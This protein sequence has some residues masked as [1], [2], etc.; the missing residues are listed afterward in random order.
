MPYDPTIFNINPYYDDY[1]PQKGFLRVLF[2]PGYALQ[3]R[4]A[5]QI[6]SILQNQLSSVADHLF[7]DGARI[8]GGAISIR[9]AD[10]LMIK[11]TGTP[12]APNVLQG[13]TDF[14]FLVG[15]YVSVGSGSASTLAKVVHYIEPDPETDN[16][17][18]LILDFLSGT[19]FAG[20]TTVKWAS[21][22]D[23]LPPE[24]ALTSIVRTETLQVETKSWASGRCKLV[25]VDDGIFY[26][27][28]FFVYSQQ[29]NFSPYR[30]ITLSTPDTT[31]PSGKVRDLGFGNFALLNKK[32][33]FSV[34]RDNVTDQEDTTLRDPAIGSYNYNA[35]GAD[36]YK[37]VLSMD[38]LDGDDEVPDFVEL[39]KYEDG[40]VI[41][42]VERVAYGE[43]EKALAIR[44]YDESGSYTVSLNEVQIREG[45]GNTMSVQIGPGKSYVLGH[46]LENNNTVF[47]DL[48]KARDVEYKAS[49]GNTYQFSVSLYTGVS[50]G[51]SNSFGETFGRYF[52]RICGGQ[53]QITAYGSTGAIVNRSSVHGMIPY[54]QNN[55]SGGVGK[56]GNHY[57]MYFNGISGGPGL[58]GYIY[59]SGIT[60]GYISGTAAGSNFAV[61]RGALDSQTL[62]YPLKP[63]NAVDNITSFRTRFKVASGQDNTTNSYVNISTSPSGITTY[64]KVY[65]S[66]LYDISTAGDN[67][68]NFP[69]YTNVTGSGNSN[70]FKHLAFVWAGSGNSAGLAFVPNG[71]NA[72]LNTG[73]DENGSYLEFAMPANLY[74][75]GFTASTA[76]IRAVVPIEY[77]PNIPTD[78]SAP[79]DFRYKVL[80]GTTFTI[81]SSVGN[82]DT[83]INLSTAYG[84]QRKSFPLGHS[85]IHSI[86]KITAVDNS[87][88]PIRT[89]VTDDFELDNGQRTYYYGTGRIIVKESEDNKA[90]YTT[91][92]SQV[93]LEVQYKYFQHKGLAG[94][95]F[96]GKHSYVHNE[97][98]GFKYEQIPLFNNTSGRIP[99]VSLANC[100]DFRRGTGN[101][102]MKPYGRSE[103]SIEGDTSVSYTHWLPR[104]DKLCL[105]E[106]P[107][108][109]S[110]VFYIIE[111]EPDLSP[112][113]PV[114]PDDGLV[115][116]TITV[117]AY[118]HSADDVIVT[119]VD[120]RRFT[121]SEIG[122]IQ[123]RIDEVEVFTK[124][125]I[126]ESE[127]SSR[128]MKSTATASEPIKT[129]ILVDEFYGHS[130][131]DVCDTGHRCSIDYERGILY[132]FFRTEDI[133]L[134]SPTSGGVTF[135]SDGLMMLRY[136]EKEYISN[137]KFTGRIQVNPSNI[138]NFLGFMKLSMPIIPNF[139][140]FYRP[141]VKT[142]ALM[143]NDNWLSSNANNDRGF[144]TQ[145][146]QWESL[147][148]GIE[149]IEEEQD[150]IQ[151]KM[152]ELPHSTN[153][154]AVPGWLSGS[155]KVGVSRK[156][157]SVDQKVDNYI[158]S[159]RLK[160][161]IKQK[162]ANRIVD[163]SVVP[164][165]PFVSGITATV[166]GLKPNATG[167]ALYLDGERL[168]SGI[169]TDG[170]GS[171]TVRFGIS[172]GTF[173]T[174]SKV[175]RIADSSVVANS[176]MSAET[177]L[178][179]TGL[180]EQKSSGV[181]STRPI[182]LRRQTPDTETIF[183]DPFNRNTDTLEG[184]QWTD[185]LSQTFFVDKKTHP[186]GIFL[187]SVDLFFT[188]KDSRLPVTIQIR[189]TVGGYPSPSVVMPFSTVTKMPYQVFTSPTSPRTTNF[190]FS[191]PV[192]LEPG[193]YAICILTNSDK[194]RVFAAT[195]S[196]NG[197]TPSTS[198]GDS[199]NG[200]VGNNQLIGSLFK[201]N[202]LGTSIQDKAVDLMF[203]VR[204]CDFSSNAIESAQYTITN[205]LAYS[206]G[207]RVYA[208]EIIPAGCSIR[209]TITG[210]GYSRSV[211]NNETSY[212]THSSLPRDGTLK[213]DLFR[214]SN[215]AVSPVVDV[216]AAC[217]TAIKLFTI[218]QPTISSYISRVVELPE[219]YESD[220]LYLAADIRDPY[221]P[222]VGNPNTQNMNRVK[223]YYRT[224]LP[225]EDDIDDAISP[226]GIFAKSWK[227][228]PARIKPGPNENALSYSESQYIEYAFK[229][230]ALPKFCK[231]QIR[232]DLI[233]E[234]AP[235]WKW[236]PSV[237]NLKAISYLR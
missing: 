83:N 40:R 119:P 81:Q 77:T 11:I 139:D 96:I 16:R 89:D 158:R 28:G 192:Y 88:P 95:P 141:V 14:S 124:L 42:K 225:G 180:L 176:S 157:E 168:V 69:Q 76:P 216:S 187:S 134:T 143:E 128:S 41:R 200:R 100:V 215:T 186:S 188:H 44:T 68:Y 97:N 37:I 171:C 191:S 60:A 52:G 75:A 136:A 66:S 118:T 167:L 4:E 197:S 13:V 8:A 120:N 74:P 6:Q 56:I 193:E 18:I 48:P 62:V 85:D 140:S 111:G 58:S 110:A 235:V 61:T 86:T 34:E 147:W 145:F 24:A 229:Q 106:D 99:V 129:S 19:S 217:I 185:P 117:P 25:T 202:A 203:T 15:G 122:K 63:G 175:V 71:T 156:V 174:G 218:N 213:Y 90:I 195:T 232:I 149:Q 51:G 103:F 184:I 92:A 221:L 142:N 31:V 46:E 204:R 224:A 163:R 123:K 214:G 115:L 205:E 67:V 94:A 30:P 105:K 45:S 43:I 210:T 182:E 169:T 207:I 223:V 227:E 179:C 79:T 35:P 57:R 54:P 209:R 161:R 138:V 116:A 181:H 9:N 126:K 144:G 5:T 65:K 135:T 53:S 98:P 160:N 162:I 47:V 87:V 206:Q 73:T 114:D 148:T 7:K 228:F 17:L 125:S 230:D 233:C 27:D 3:A 190:K 39:V 198:G 201:P 84:G 55:M 32:I 93:R 2:K 226:G 50:V 59:L 237:K 109:G 234:A 178:H 231:Y 159:S 152:L 222:L 220:G 173:L 22:D 137:K 130:V 166:H 49:E 113:P 177:T 151:Q 112:V 170:Y 212:F 38:Q 101:Q 26:V 219:G 23:D 20:Q 104:I 131:A 164:Y 102:M 189:P 211:K 127:L 29:Q 236:I 64:Y 82:Q 121:M 199:D 21:D 91:A 194:Y 132:P 146:N 12:A 208:P 165:I 72:V 36:R 183:K 154:S 172:S 196:R 33:G 70:I 153:D 133:T 108:D 80:T 10:Y 1:D 78:G 150:D 107:I 155:E